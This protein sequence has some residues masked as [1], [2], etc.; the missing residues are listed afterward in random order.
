MWPCAS[1]MR[2]PHSI[3][4]GPMLKLYQPDTDELH[5]VEGTIAGTYICLTSYILSI[6]IFNNPTHPLQLYSE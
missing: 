6:A 5:T 3:W 1:G 4:C 2:T